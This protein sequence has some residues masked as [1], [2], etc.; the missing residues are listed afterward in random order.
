MGNTGDGNEQAEQQHGR[1][2]RKKVI[3]LG[4]RQLALN[5]VKLGHVCETWVLTQSLGS[6]D[7]TA[8]TLFL[9][10][11]ALYTGFVL[12]RSWGFYPFLFLWSDHHPFQI[13][14]LLIFICLLRIDVLGNRLKSAII[15]KRTVKLTTYNLRNGDQSQFSCISPIM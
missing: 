10:D 2:R 8:L 5:A 6:F 14:Y 4:K 1:S 13:L 9:W 3:W 7:Q 15:Q 11:H 12:F